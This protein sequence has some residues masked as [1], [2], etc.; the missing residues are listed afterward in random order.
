LT[1]A[2]TVLGL[3]GIGLAAQDPPF[4]FQVAAPTQDSAQVAVV[5][6]PV[7]TQK[8]E[9]VSAHFRD[10]KVAEVLAW[11]EQQGVNFVLSDP[12][13]KDRTITLNID[14]Q[15]LDDVVDSIASALGGHWEHK[16]KIRVF[17]SGTGGF[18][19]LFSSARPGVNVFGLT[20]DKTSPFQ[21]T[22]PKSGDQKGLQEYRFFTTPPNG[23]FKGFDDKSI[24]DLLKGQGNDLRVFTF[25]APKVDFEKFVKSLSDHQKELMK[26]QGYLKLDDLTARQREMIGVK[27][28][29]ANMTI[30]Y[31]ANG[32]TVT[33]K[34]K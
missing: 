13:I 30:T 32:Q 8:Q 6:D 26:S 10:A 19:D 34:S 23:Q 24:Q 7:Q 15:P 2:A 4:D 11:L 12:A 25:G 17:H 27:G 9:G 20:P 5:S 33:I 31:T 1:G 22:V 16:G 3:A 29:P 18:T 21:F 14:G 28:S